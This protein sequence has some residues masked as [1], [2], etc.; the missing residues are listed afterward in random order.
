MALHGAGCLPALF[1]ALDSNLLG[2]L[3]YGQFI[4]HTW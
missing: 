3:S 4:F 1:I 2:E